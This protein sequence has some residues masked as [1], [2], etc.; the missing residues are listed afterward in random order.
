M[1]S[2]GDPRVHVADPD[3]GVEALRVV[4]DRVQQVGLAEAGLAVDEQRVVR[5]RRRL[6]D[7]DRR[8]VRE[9]VAGADHEGV[10]GVLRVQPRLAGRAG[11]AGGA[12]RTGGWS[13]R[14]GHHRFCRRR[15]PAAWSRASRTSITASDGSEVSTMTAR[16]ICWPI[17]GGEKAGD[18]PRM[19]CSRTYFVRSFGAASSAGAVEQADRGV[20]RTKAR[21]CGVTP[22]DSRPPGPGPRSWGSPV[23][24][25]HTAHLRA[26]AVPPHAVTVG[27]HRC[28]HTVQDGGARNPA[29]RTRRVET[30]C[31]RQER[32]IAGCHPSGAPLGTVRTDGFG[33]VRAG[34]LV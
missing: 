14:S 33:V 6:R 5:L 8:G 19:R 15:H 2:F 9:P 23:R 16:R 29:G 34:G 27:P 10:E 21:C 25:G 32:T 26:T 1:K 31:D 11:R 28:P 3:A 30:A 22:A 17:L 18:G 13:V 20:R 24:R 12:A 7:G 4:P